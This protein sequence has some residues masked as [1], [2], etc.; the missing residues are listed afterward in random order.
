MFS[1]E[2]SAYPVEYANYQFNS[3]LS[4][5]CRAKGNILWAKEY[6]E[7]DEGFMLIPR[8]VLIK[9]DNIGVLSTENLLVYKPDGSFRYMLPIGSNTPVVFGKEAMAY[10]VPANLLNYQDYS[11]KLI[12]ETG[13]FPSMEEWAYIVLFKPEKKEFIAAVH[14]TGGPKPMM[15]PET[16]DVYRKQIEKSLVKWRYDGDGPLD[17]AM[18]TT[19]NRKIVIMRKSK[20]NLLDIMNINVESGFDLEFE[21]IGTASLDTENNLVFIGRGARNKGV[22]PFLTKVSLAGKL[23]WEHE[24]RNPQTHQPPVCG[25]GGQVYVVDGGQLKSIDKGSLKWK[26]ELKSKEQALMTITRDNSVILLQGN[27][28][29]VIYETGKEK[30]SSKI[31]NDEESFDAPP[32]VDS[33]GRIYIASDKKLYCFE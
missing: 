13:E 17:R 6:S 21:E 2:G 30:F 24:L 16:F 26:L 7:A 1:L 5:D 14:F 25:S 31:T 23:L 11:G 33:Q 15:Q 22:R 8:S 9:D 12:L 3:H 29:S 4:I 28:L 32:A 19:D 18:L 27:H 10:L 20:V